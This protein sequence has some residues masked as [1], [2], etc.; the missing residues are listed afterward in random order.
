MFDQACRDNLIKRSAAALQRL[1]DHMMKNL[2]KDFYDDE[3]E[4]DTMKSLEWFIQNI[5]LVAK[6]LKEDDD[7]TT[8]MAGASLS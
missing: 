1:Q 5:E 7:L 2:K 8:Q 4:A 6:T 3:K